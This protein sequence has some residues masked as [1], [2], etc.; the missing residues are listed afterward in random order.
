M[1]SSLTCF[2]R[3]LLR[4]LTGATALTCV[5]ALLA[6]FIQPE[7]ETVPV[8]RVIAN[9]EA[10]VRKNPKDANA[11]FN[12]ARAHAMAFAVKSE[13]AQVRRGGETNGVWFDFTPPHIPFVVK[14]TE[15]AG[16]L[17]AAKDHLEKA[18]ASYR[19]VLK[20]QPNHFSARLGLAWCLLQSGD[21]AGAVKEFRA[22]I[23]LAWDKEKNMEAAGLDFHS[24][25]AEGSRYLTP[26]LDAEKDRNELAELKERVQK[27][28]RIMRP[29]T[30]V[31]VPLRAGLRADELVDGRAR[32]RFDADGTG[33]QHTWT[34]LTPDAAWLVHD[35][36][37]SGKITSALQWFGGVTFWMFWQDGYAAMASLDNDGDGQLAGGE[38]AGLSLW[39]D[40]NGNG[41]SDAG[42]VRPLSAHGIVALNCRGQR[43]TGSA[44]AAWCAK[45]VTLRDG[46][47]RP[48][49]DL[50][51]QR[52]ADDPASQPQPSPRASRSSSSSPR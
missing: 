11:R 16:K 6:L 30:P 27:V 17:K 43:G 40:V 37:G 51:L 21:K 10:L 8:A 45:G 18:V 25:V 12:I 31:A 4:T 24:V 29:I 35:P 52:V 47:T 22:V 5:P 13:S 9:L 7:I 46:S 42:E 36:A 28:N 2:A 39:H 48:T 49:Y 20:A 50:I 3:P 33:W 1:K 23:Q 19:D 15:D 38:L 26:L 34:W 14:P 44:V 41:V 32:V